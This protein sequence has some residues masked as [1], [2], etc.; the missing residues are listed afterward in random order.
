MKFKL[1]ALLALLMGLTAFAQESRHEELLNLNWQF[2][3]DGGIWRRVDLPHDFQLER[4]WDPKASPARGYKEMG[5]AQYEKDLYVK[6]E[7]AGK[8]VILDIGGIMTSGDVWVNGEK[9]ADIDYGYVG[10]DVDMTSKIR[11]GDNNLI[12]IHA[13]TGDVTGSR[14]YTGGGLFRDVK[15]I[16]KDSISIARN[17]LFI[18]TPRITENV[19]DV[20]IQVTMEG[21]RKDKVVELQA[22]I[23]DPYGRVVAEGHCLSP[24]RARLRLVEVDMP[25]IT[26]PAPMLWSC[27]TP[28]LYK[29]EVVVLHNGKEV[30]RLSDDFGI[31][32]IEFSPEFGFRLNGK[33]V[34]L[35]G[36]A[37]HH[38]L[39]A[40]GAAAYDRSIERYF[41][42][43]KEFGFNHVRTSHNPY[44]RNFIKL[45][46]KY[47]ILIVDEY[48]DKCARG[49]TWP[50]STS[51]FE[52]F[53]TSIPEWIKRDR[54]SPSV[55]MW[56]LGNELQTNDNWYG[57]QTDD[58]GVT[59]YKMLDVL[60]KRYDTTRPTTVAM[61]P[62][63]ANGSRN[64]PDFNTNP[65]PPELSLVTEIA[66]YNYQYPAY[67]R[68]LSLHPDLIIYQSEA[69]TRELSNAYYGMNYDTMVGLAY[70][71]AVEY[72]GESNGWPKKGWSFSFFNH[73]LEPYPQAYLI[74]SM[75]KP[76][77]P[78]VRIAVSDGDNVSIEWNDVMVG[79][80]ELSSHWNYRRN[81]KH[82]VFVYSNAQ[83]VELVVNGRSL[84]R[85]K[86]VITGE[87]GRN[88]LSWPAV[89]Y[90]SGGKIVAIARNNGKEVARHTIETAG[91][92]VALKAVVENPD[93]WKGDGIDLQY[94]RVYAV[95][96][97]GR[98]VPT[99]EGL[100]R[101]SCQ[102]AARIQAVD[103]GDNFTDKVYTQGNEV[104]MKKGFCMA[105]LRT[106]DMGVSSVLFTAS[107]DGLRTASVRLK[108][109]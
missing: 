23:Y 12:A 83:E 20:Q 63:R 76:E 80:A 42:R 35:K 30:D 22:K 65:N 68:Y 70:W 109:N 31:R 38:D 34:F 47:G 8:K 94:I 79:K 90:G 48:C 18:T 36:V 97:R 85:K 3:Y 46:D 24:D 1:F 58:W 84:G 4:P 67:R 2:K 101:F 52:S 40:V 49:A 32:T 87:T 61:F 16:V 77:E 75:F 71:G 98:E 81:S 43:L 51:F 69:A 29:A 89:N 107:M 86:N 55:I 106:Y 44:S 37:G 78:M 92:A 45:A 103:D 33:K 56:S 11:F 25:V 19:A 53:P 95:D 108:T 96:S 10:C 15:L 74:K 66:S 41:K 91:K 6:P 62:A 105:I 13:T 27:E 14:W 73:S 100:V 64:D 28:N 88:I 57:F 82:D 5:K 54:N 93:D 9:M 72:W 59:T 60:V 39:G 99:K 21:L 104:Q 102:G 50:G 7:W 26:V 17:G